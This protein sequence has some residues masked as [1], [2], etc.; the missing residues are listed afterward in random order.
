MKQKAK[1]V[2]KLMA[3]VLTVA[4]SLVGASY[5]TEIISGSIARELIGKA[6]EIM[7]IFTGASLI[8]L[9]LTNTDSPQNN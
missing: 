9:L 7:G 6:I 3:I 8:V 4:I 2:L 1:L 5:V